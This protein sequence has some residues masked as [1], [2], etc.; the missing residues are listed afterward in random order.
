M[1]KEKVLTDNQK[2]FIQALLGDAKGDFKLAKKLAGYSDTVSVNEIIR[3][4]K[5]ELREAAMDALTMASIKSAFAMDAVL[6]DPNL[7]GAGNLLKA[8]D[9]VLTRVGAK[10]D[11]NVIKAPEGAVLILPEKKFTII[12]IKEEEE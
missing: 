4:L 8:A 12:Q 9:S 6:S 3:S 2:A 7:P 5:N 10:V 11:E 1:A